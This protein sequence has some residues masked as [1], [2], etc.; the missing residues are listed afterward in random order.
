C[1]LAYGYVSSDD[2]VCCETIDIGRNRLTLWISKNHPLAGKEPL[3]LKDL[4]GYQY[5]LPSNAQFYEF[6]HSLQ[7]LFAASGVMPS[8]YYRSSETFLE[9]L[10]SCDGCKDIL[11]G[12]TGIEHHPV[13]EMKEDMLFRE[14]DD[15][16]E[17]IPAYIVYNGDSNNPAI[18][19]FLEHLKKQRDI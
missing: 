6:E 1:G 12:T 5:P 19:Q 16:S 18:K 4:N 17:D 13:L 15:Y 14:F 11:L 10:L 3:Q 8:F 9:F 2:G 7:D